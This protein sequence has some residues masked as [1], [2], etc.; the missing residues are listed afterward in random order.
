MNASSRRWREIKKFSTSNHKLT[1]CERIKRRGQVRV[2]AG[3]P[4]AL[5]SSSSRHPSS[6]TRS[7]SKSRPLI[8]E[9]AAATDA[10]MGSIDWACSFVWRLVG[11]MERETAHRSLLSTSTSALPPW[12]V[13][14]EFFK[15]CPR[16]CFSS[17]CLLGTVRHLNSLLWELSQ[18]FGCFLVLWWF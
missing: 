11:V 13:L 5:V 4:R 6:W 10:Q 2:S 8:S 17:L 15:F 12:L 7:H 1:P 16:T 14:L 3:W 18:Y 9:G